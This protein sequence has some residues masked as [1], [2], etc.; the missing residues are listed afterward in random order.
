M[1]ALQSVLSD[2]WVILQFIQ[3]V[4]GV[5]IPTLGF[6]LWEDGTITWKR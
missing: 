6:T 2:V 3:T 1:E 4:T 5:D